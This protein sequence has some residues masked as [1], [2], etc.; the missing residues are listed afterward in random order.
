MP[1]TSPFKFLDAYTKTDK[2]IFFGRD[3][4]I[5]QLYNLI[6]Q[7]NLTLVYG[8]S[9][10]GKTSLVQCGLA[11]RFAQSDWF[12]IYLRRNENINE[13][14]LRTLKR[15]EVVSTQRG[16]LMERLKK[17][18]GGV[19]KEGSSKPDKKSESSNEVIESLRS[20]SKHY[21]KPIFL[22]FDQFEELFI[23]GT[24]E[25]QEKFYD[26]IA[27]IL[28][29]EAYTRI[30]FIMREESIAQLSAFEK[31]V[32]FLFEKRLRVEPMSRL[33]TEE[34]ITQ[35]CA[36]FDIALE[37]EQVPTQI[38]E[39][40][41]EGKA[42]V[43]LTYL[44]VFL[45]QLFQEAAQ[46]NLDQITFDSKLIQKVGSIEDVLGDFL[47]RQTGSIQGRFAQNFPNAPLASVQKVLSAFVTLEGTK[48]PMTK[49]DVKVSNLNPEEIGFLVDELEKGRIL[50]FENNLFEL[51]HDTLAL[52]IA[53]ER[54]ADEVALLQIA[55]IVRDRYQVSATT[56]ALLNSNEL[57]LINNYRGRIEEEGL[58]AA[59]EW[60]FVKK[61]AKANTR[62][63]VF[64][65]SIIVL[66]LA[67]M[68]G[69]TIYSSQ[70]AQEALEQKVKAEYAL[71]KYKEAEE[72]K[73]EAQYQSALDRGN[74]A[75]AKNEYPAA[76]EAYQEALKIKPDGEEAAIK[77][78]EA[79][80]R[81]DI[82]GDFDK[83]M[84]EG[85][86]LYEKG[87]SNYI[88]ALNKFKAALDLNY[89]N[90]KAQSKV[91]LLNGKMDSA[92]EGFKN[93]GDKFFKADE[94]KLALD[95]Y[96]E[97]R[98]IKPSNSYVNQ[99]IKDCKSQLN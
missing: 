33:K 41:G 47:D 97:A 4:E 70:L 75:F 85:D 55:K 34:V 36:K 81:S 49:S 58:L 24:K 21:L 65:G 91:D 31:V 87:P 74:A 43:E 73:S 51:S 3:E 92:F 11:N 8:Q 54:G 14:L 93:L 98:R 32:P 66:L 83:L 52:R 63:L 76:I 82:R 39:V 86:A 42:R 72:S 62:R 90:S 68:T 69:F 7:S 48:R 12:D 50:R 57:Q 99:R 71:M 79:M 25:E 23:L 84:A 29:T 80:D 37:D 46:D 94:F 28:D 1:A 20:M 59:E 5:E 35:T 96:L 9:G 67:T 27:E 16:T 17:K 26:T 15:F 38:I 6:F 18:R 2:D 61:S 60:E 40:L 22:I 13:S 30:I 53:N 89:N 77:V 78:Q 64:I 88:A 95:Q 45:D 44:Q 56:K 10:T 19:A